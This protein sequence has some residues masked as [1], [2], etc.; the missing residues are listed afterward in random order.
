MAGLLHHLPALIALTTPSTNSYRRL[1]PHFWS[2]A[3]R[4]WG[5]DHREAAIRVPSNPTLPSPTH[6]ELRTVDATANPY[7][8]LGG[9]IAAGL[10]GIQQNLEL[11][12]P[13]ISDPGHASEE[14]RQRLRIDRLPG[15]LGE[16][17]AHLSQ[18]VIL[19]QSLGSDLAQAYLAVRKAEW[20]TLQSYSLEE[21][22]RLL[23]EKY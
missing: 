4:C 15:N 11:G 6:I 22:V 8:A 2:G 10:D 16:A 7:I 14:E 21:E 13:V 1:Q 3:F 5:M 19:Q 20:E 12:Q 9:A 18:N 17:I 23:L